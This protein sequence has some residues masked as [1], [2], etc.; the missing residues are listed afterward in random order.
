MHKFNAERMTGLGQAGQPA[1]PDSELQFMG[2]VSNLLLG[3]FA[4]IKLSLL[5][6]TV[7]L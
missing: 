6:A 3:V 7:Q 2:G 1:V 4:R 5:C